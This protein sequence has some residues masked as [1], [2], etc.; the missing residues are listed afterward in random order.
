MPD[1][2]LCIMRNFMPRQEWVLNPGDMLYLPPGVA[3]HGVALEDCI[4]L[5]VGF[6]AP[7]HAELLGSFADYAASQLS[8]AQ[9]FADPDLSVQQHPG[10]ISTEALTQVRSILQ[11]I[12]S[13][14]SAM[15]QWFGEFITEPKNEH[16]PED[17]EP[18][19][20]EEFLHAFAEHGQL[21]RVEQIRFAFI[22]DSN[23]LFVNG[24]SYPLANELAFAAPLLC[25]Q[26]QWSYSQLQSTLAH[27][28]FAKLLTT[29][30]NQAYVIF[31]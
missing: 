5:S 28:D 18:L 4:T 11:K 27:A 19:N 14:D 29:L 3:H 30:Y 6:R 13:D 24:Q 16:L 1:I 15:E 7:S 20:E 26:R 22:A 8:A 12:L 2:D 17:V 10:E 31:E 9:R 23:T 25:D 21:L